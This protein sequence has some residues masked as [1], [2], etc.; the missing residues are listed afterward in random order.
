[1]APTILVVED[2]PAVREVVADLL[3]AAGYAVRTAADGRAALAAV[4]AERPA[5]VLADVAMPGLDG[6]SLAARLRQLA[7]PVPIVLLSGHCPPAPPAGL[8]CLAKPFAAA[9]LVAAVAAALGA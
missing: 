8:T 7:R 4:E 6:W 2:D 1:M 9:D 3:A 5:L